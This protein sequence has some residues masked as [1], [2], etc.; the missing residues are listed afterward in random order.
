M[1]KLILN[2][3]VLLFMAG[4]FFGWD[5]AGWRKFTN[6]L[7]YNGIHLNGIHLNGIHLNGTSTSMDCALTDCA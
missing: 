5:D 4:W 1:R 6:T 2:F 7:S 3:S